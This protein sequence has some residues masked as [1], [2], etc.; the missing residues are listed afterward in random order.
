VSA[1]AV[2]RHS[3]Y[4]FFVSNARVAVIQLDIAEAFI[5]GYQIEPEN[6]NEH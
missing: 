3:I 4:Y 1:I 5:D 6:I 2:I